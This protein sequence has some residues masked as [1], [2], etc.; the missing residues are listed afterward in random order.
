M[1]IKH[2][3]RLSSMLD[4]LFRFMGF[5]YRHYNQT[6]EASSTKGW[7]HEKWVRASLKTLGVINNWPKII[8][9]SWRGWH[10]DL[11]GYFWKWGIFFSRKRRL[12]KAVPRVNFLFKTPAY[13][14]RMEGIRIR[15]CHTSYCAY[16]VR[17]VIA[18]G[19]VFFRKLWK[20]V[21]MK[22]KS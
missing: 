8:T 2:T 20:K 14:F 17:H 21:S 7:D 5:S 18:C 11:R 13:R 16:P 1:T 22:K 10:T 3:L 12:S 15:W 9:H 4:M 19:Y 6:Y